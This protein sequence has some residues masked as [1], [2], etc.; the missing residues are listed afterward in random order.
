VR[1]CYGIKTGLNPAFLIDQATRDRLIAEDPRSAEVIKP[2][3]RGDHIRRYEIHFRDLYLIF[4]RQGVDLG[5]YPAVL[6]HLERF[7][8][9]L[10]PK[11]SRTDRRGRKPG[12]YAWYEIQDTVEYHQAFDLPKI[13]YPVIGKEP[14]FVRDGEGYYANDKAFLLPGGDWYLLGV[15]NSA[16]A[17]DYL[18]G[19]CSVLGDE[20]HGG[21]LEFRKAFLQTLPVPD[22]PAAERGAVARLARRAQ[23]LHTARR[24]RVERFLTDLGTGPA[25]LGRHGPLERPWLLTPVQFA[26]R[27]RGGDV[28]TFTAAR[29]ETQALTAATLRVEDE[30]DLRVGA[31]YGLG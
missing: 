11:A 22:A 13:L 27:V 4:T 5:R 7:R 12:P 17:F 14:R 23:Q 24:R 21:R 2:L 26:G 1:I 8:A 16:A 25:K 30:I 20:N 28:R 18:K 9:D 19:T 15:L 6:R 29:E 31:L 10:T 3:L